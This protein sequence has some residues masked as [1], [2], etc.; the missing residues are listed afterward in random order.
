MTQQLGE[1]VTVGCKRAFTRRVWVTPV[2][3]AGA[4]VGPTVIGTQHITA[5]DGPLHTRYEAVVRAGLEG[6]VDPHQEVSAI[7]CRNPATGLDHVHPLVRAAQ[8]GAGGGGWLVDTDLV[9]TGWC[10]RWGR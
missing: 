4:R 9:M 10:W 7:R 6:D 8:Y 3:Q 1:V 2:N 5:W